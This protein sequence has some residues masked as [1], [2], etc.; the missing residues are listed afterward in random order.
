[1]FQE[2]RLDK[3]PAF[4]CMRKIEVAAMALIHITSAGITF[5]ENMVDVNSI[6]P[7]NR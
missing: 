7:R 1:M 6:F 5:F 2:F 3:Q 4:P